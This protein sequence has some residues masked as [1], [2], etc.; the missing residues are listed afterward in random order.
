MEVFTPEHESII[1][2]MLDEIEP[3]YKI[4]RQKG[5]RWIFQKPADKAID[6]KQAEALISRRMIEDK[7]FEKIKRILEEA[8]RKASYPARK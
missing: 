4:K 7:E 3:G 6:V 5:E 2:R 8:I 1:Q